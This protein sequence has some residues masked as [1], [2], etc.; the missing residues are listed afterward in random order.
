M[1]LLAVLGECRAGFGR[2][3]LLFGGCKTLEPHSRRE[4]TPLPLDALISYYLAPDSK[5]AI[6]P[7]GRP[8]P[9][10]KRPPQRAPRTDG[11]G[12]YKIPT[13]R[14]YFDVAQTS[15]HAVSVISTA[16]NGNMF[17]LSN[18]GGPA[19]NN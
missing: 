17:P 19:F 13:G 14:T 15:I 8:K 16:L 11:T 10:A 1:D 12:I 18:L 5:D 9:I 3:S 7:A 2:Q 4:L 6:G